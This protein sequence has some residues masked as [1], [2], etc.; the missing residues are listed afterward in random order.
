MKYSKTFNKNNS[1]FPD[2]Y[3]RLKQIPNEYLL[4]NIHN[5]P[6][7]HP[8]AILSISFEDIIATIQ[9]ILNLLD[10]INC[11]S[12]KWPTLLSTQKVLYNDICSFYDECYML[13]IPSSIEKCK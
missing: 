7:R 12:S 10:S 13:L 4:H 1:L 9:Q 5:P 11:D 8:G 3:H 2:V 6:L